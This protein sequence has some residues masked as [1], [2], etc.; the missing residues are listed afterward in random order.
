VHRLVVRQRV[1]V[2]PQRIGGEPLRVLEPVRDARRVA[3]AEIHF[4]A[5]AGR[6]DRRLLDRTRPGQVAQRIAERIGREHHPL[7][8]VERRGRVVESDGV[9]RHGA[10]KWL[11]F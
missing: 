9:E 7:A 1:Q 6:Q 11:I 5:V 8:H 2:R 3:V 10:A 4:G